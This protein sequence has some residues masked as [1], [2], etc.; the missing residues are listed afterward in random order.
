[1]RTIHRTKRKHLSHSVAQCGW[2]KICSA[3]NLYYPIQTNRVPDAACLDDTGNLFFNC[4]WK[5]NTKIS[6]NKVVVF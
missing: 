3:S 5:D 4:I 6:S 2:S 1:M